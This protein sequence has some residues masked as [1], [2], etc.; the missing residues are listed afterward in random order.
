MSTL[1]GD[2][3]PPNTKVC[4][5]CKEELSLDHFSNASG[6]NYKRSACRRC[7]L[8]L[9]KDR[10]RIKKD[11]PLLNEDDHTC[12]ICE[13]SKDEV[14]G[15]GG[16][17]VGAWVSDHNHKTGKFRNYLCHDCNRGLG[18]FKDSFTNLI[19]AAEYIKKHD[20]SI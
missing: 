4:T 17:K 6:G 11:N 5:K 2:E 16:K 9:S 20:Q 12:P 10:D 18:V 19:K 3:D 13:R 14:S 1:F 8:S 15:A 7:E